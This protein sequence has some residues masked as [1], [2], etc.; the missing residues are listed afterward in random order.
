MADRLEASLFRRALGM[1]LP[2][3]H[4]SSYEGAITVTPLTKHLPP[5]TLALIFA[6]KNVR[7]S[8]WSDKQMLDVQGTVAGVPEA[9]LDRLR[10]MHRAEQESK[11]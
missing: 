11:K 8:N 9:V 7:G 5:D 3:C 1:T 10:A 2:D 6:L 4:V